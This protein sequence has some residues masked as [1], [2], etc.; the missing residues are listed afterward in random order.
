MKNKKYILSMLVAAAFMTLAYY[1]PAEMVI[2][3]F[4][5]WLFAVPIA[6]VAFVT[7]GIISYN[8]DAKNRIVV[9]VKPDYRM[10]LLAKKEV[11]LQI[12]KEL[13]IKEF[14]RE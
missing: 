3:F 5:G 9:A 2:G 4:V 14:K 11:E 6:V 7:Y 12:E 8:K 10:T 13:L 1:Y